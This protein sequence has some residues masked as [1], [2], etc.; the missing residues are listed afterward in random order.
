MRSQRAARAR[1]V[2]RRARTPSALGTEL[3]RARALWSPA[4]TRRVA[5]G[6]RRL[7]RMRESPAG[8]RLCT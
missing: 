3:L 8:A 7:L 6:H 2:P 1:R 4:W 5:G